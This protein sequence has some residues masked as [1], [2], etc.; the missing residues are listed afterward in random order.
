[1][2]LHGPHRPLALAFLAEGDRDGEDDRECDCDEDG[3]RTA[4]H[5]V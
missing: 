5:A 3:V 1:L 2:R 4:V